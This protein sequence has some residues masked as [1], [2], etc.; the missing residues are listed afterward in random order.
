MSATEWVKTVLN[1]PGEI[2]Q[3]R[4]RFQEFRVVCD[5]CSEDKVCKVQ[6]EAIV[7]LEEDKSI[8]KLSTYKCYCIVFGKK[9]GLMEAIKYRRWKTIGL[10][11]R[12][13]KKLYNNV[14]ETRV[15]EAE[16]TTW[17]PHNSFTG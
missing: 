14:L 1:S 3:A 10:M 13:P 9:R 2:R 11:T 16:M 17:I 5:R 7:T 15:A 12:S 6:E 8:D 4:R